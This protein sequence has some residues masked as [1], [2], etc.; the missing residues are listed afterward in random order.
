MSDR[1]MLLGIAFGAAILVA[2]AVGFFAYEAGRSAAPSAYPLTWS[3]A[4]SV[5]MEGTLC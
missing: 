3:S 4:V 5:P 1:L 2:A